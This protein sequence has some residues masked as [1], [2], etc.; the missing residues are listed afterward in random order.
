MSL[1]KIKNYFEPK[2]I[3]DIGA[4]TGQFYREISQIFPNAYYFL[5]EGNDGCEIPLQSIGVD[6]SIAM[7]SD[8]EKI[9]K[10]YIRDGEPLCTGNSI[11][12]ENSAFY[13]EDK[14]IVVE[15]DTKTLPQVLNNKLFDLIKIDVQGSELDIIKGGLDI[16]KSS[17]GILM[18]VS[19]VE[20]NQGAP[21][22][23]EVIS[24]ME[25]IGFEPVEI[26]ANIN[27]PMFHTLIQED[28]LFLNKNI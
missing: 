21:T 27:H 20:F 8:C 12:K 23:Q 3:L 7:L 16:I 6:Y 11:Y 5:I 19:L 26:I 25:E 17:K 2:S 13:D 4:N 14:I 24:F 15:K 1:S 22:K 10:Y 28:I 18:E 9:V